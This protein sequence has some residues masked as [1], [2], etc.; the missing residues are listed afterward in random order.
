MNREDFMLL[1]SNIIYF[2]NAATTLK[3]K[4][5]SETISEY[6]NSYSSNKSR[7][8]YF[9]ARKTDEMY[10]K[11]REKVKNFIGANNVR[12]IVFTNNATD[13]MNKLV[14]GYF[15]EILNEDD[16]V[17]LTVSEHASNILPWLEL[18][19]QIGIKVKYIPLNEK[20]EL[21]I[22]SVRNSITNK[23]KVI[24]IAH[25][26]NVVGDIRDIEKI[27]QLANEKNIK[28]IIDGA[29]SVPHKKI[30]ISGI[31][32][33]FLVF[34]AHKMLG[35]TG[36]GVLY[37][38]EDL[39]DEV[40]PIIFG[41]GMNN[42]FDLEGNVIY[43]E[44]PIKLEAG[45][46]NIAGV[47]GFGIIIDYLNEIGMENIEQYEL[48]LKKY[49][50]EKMKELDNIIIYNE[51]SLGS[52]VTFNVKDI[53]PIE[54]SNYLDKYNICI[55][56]GKHCAKILNDV[57]GVPNTCRA[58]FYFYNTK[59]EIDRFVAVLKKIKKG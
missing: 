3:P 12:E 19:K 18:S 36:V 52:I 32:A 25:I 28:V 22:E 46:P 41:G 14:F 33:H 40:Y 54:V 13:S 42:Y 59:D 1:D 50:I 5:L 53:D 49:A 20:F 24:S 2:D 39:C 4:I 7:G 56:S 57:I 48:N 10:E 21:D 30:D 34:S 26:T 11:T 55:R 23:T 35:P 38:K 37:V 44:M 9:I 16:E 45:T 15:K 31:G 58:S 47:I 17:L 8:S 27:V 43:E 51:N 29:Q 6:Y